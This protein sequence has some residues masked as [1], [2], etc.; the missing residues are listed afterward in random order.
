MKKTIL[1]IL[2]L[3][4]LTGCTSERDAR[5]A[6]EAHGYS[7]IEITG[8]KPFSCSE[9]D[10]YSTGFRATNPNGREVT[11]VVCSGLFFKNATVR[12]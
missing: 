4:L 11:G 2:A 9:D 7:N 5:R 10:F 3:T 6:L 1:L 8:W 12:F